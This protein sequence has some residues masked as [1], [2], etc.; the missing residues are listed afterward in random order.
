MKERIT[1]FFLLVFLCIGFIQAQNNKDF[2]SELYIGGGGGILFS[3]I[4]FQPTVPQNPHIGIHAG[5][6]AKYISQK[7]LGL[8]A[9]INFAQ[10]GWTEKY[11]AG[12]GFSYNRTLNY[13][14]I[15]FMTHIYF[16]NKV[17]FIINLGPQI[18]FLI[19]HS[20][21]MSDELAADVEA[22]QQENQDA[23]IGVQYTDPEK[24]FDYGAIGSAGMSLKTG[25]GDFDLEGRYYF[26][27]GDLFKYEDRQ[28]DFSRAAH[29]MIE[30]KLTY[31]FKL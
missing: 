25:V 26:G 16:G 15:P 6:A 13:I 9:E 7:H 5:I 3:T 23:F 22:R 31:Y 28:K 17:R 2:E 30:I 4:D 11:D 10:R 29:R 14:E 27:L 24:R 18:S 12:T 1:S 20:S 8:I 21:Q 19:S